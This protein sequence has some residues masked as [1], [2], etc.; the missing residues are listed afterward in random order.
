MDFGT[1]DGKDLNSDQKISKIEKGS[2][3]RKNYSVS[4]PPRRRG[5]AIDKNNPAGVKGLR[6]THGILKNRIEFSRNRIFISE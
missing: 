1:T 3:S 4:H 5:G 2:D 6:L